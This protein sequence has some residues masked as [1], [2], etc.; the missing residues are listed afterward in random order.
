ME[1]CLYISVIVGVIVLLVFLIQQGEKFCAP[2]N[3]GGQVYNRFMNDE[4]E[5]PVAFDIYERIEMDKNGEGGD[6]YSDLYGNGQLPSLADFEDY[7]GDLDPFE[8]L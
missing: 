1:N 7:F 8:F 2:Q 4:K 3:V 5:T 6:V